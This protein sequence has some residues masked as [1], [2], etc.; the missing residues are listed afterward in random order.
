MIEKAKE[1]HHFFYT[2]AFA[3]GLR[4]TVAILLPSLI[5]SYLG[6]FD[7]GLSISLGATCVSIT[8]APGPIIHK[9]N[10]MMYCA[11]LIFIT[12]IVTSLARMNVY[13]MGLEIILFSFLFSMFTVYGIRAGAVGSACM[14]VLILTMDRPAGQDYGFLE[15]ALIFIGGI[16]YL[17][18]SLLFYSIQPYRP[19]QRALGE[20]IRELSTYLS[21]KADF[22]NTATD[23]D[24][25]YRKL[26]AQQVVVSEKLDGVR[27]ILFK[28]RKIMRETSSVGRRLV[29]AFVDAVD[30]FEQITATFYDYSSI[31]KRFG[32]IG[33]L[34]DISLL[35]KQLSIDL[36]AIGIAIQSNTRYATTEDSNERIVTLK[37]KIDTIETKEGTSN[38][39]LKKLLVNMRN[40]QQ[41]LN[42]VTLYFDSSNKSGGRTSSREYTRFVS[43]QSFGVK[44]LLNN[45]SLES[46]IFRH[47]LRVAIA[48]ITGF[49][50]AKVISY[51]QHSYWILLTVA[52]ILKPAFGLT[53]ERNYQRIIGTITGGIIGVLILLFV[54]NKTVLF[55]LLVLFMI[56][57]YSFQRINYLVMVA[58]TTPFVF[59]LF[60]FLGYNIIDVAK[61]R[62]I[63]TI[64]GCVLAF[65][66]NYFLFPSWESNQLKN[67][68]LHMLKANALY[69]QK[70]VEA[71]SGNAIKTV[72]YKL[73][74]KDVYVSSAN[75]SAAFQRMLSEPKSKQL[76]SKQIHQFVV[77][78]HIFFFNTASLASAI[79]GKE[80]KLFPPEI[81]HSAKRSLSVL[82]ESLKQFEEEKDVNLSVP[83]KE[84]R[85]L[86][87]DA[88]MK[89]QLDFIYRLTQDI[90]KA[91]KAIIAV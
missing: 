9:R 74:R 47:S 77:L 57:N 45:F 88:S 75:L 70:L 85:A 5:L 24:E 49:V 71:L 59:I 64:I 26:L 11:V 80:S 91:T 38:L 51:G 67:Y 83:V 37:N 53:K 44:L 4:I 73:A 79:I 23:L 28:T 34:Q 55:I 66:A 63:D 52:F 84:D 36:D 62:T 19:A 60:S 31:R 16:W 7:L 46:S 43:H 17:L 14:L 18:F 27:E 8:D 58:C 42:D 68:L 50:L 35:A 20:F 81:V 78:N 15:G 89:E 69:F 25:D 54:A 82:E 30:L 87:S 72:D 61:E 90:D 12:A 33:L 39:V 56:A 21:I 13:T 1:V 48:C 65:G 6:H 41:R 32:D 10:G 76:A 40:L 3:D 2:Q 22:Y 86:T 29:L